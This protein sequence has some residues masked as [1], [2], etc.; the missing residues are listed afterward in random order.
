MDVYLVTYN[1]NRNGMTW[2]I[3]PRKRQLTSKYVDR[4]KVN[5]YYSSLSGEFCV[6]NIHF[7]FGRTVSILPVASLIVEAFYLNST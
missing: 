1:I 4:I 6:S 7:V 3:G 2:G 5:K